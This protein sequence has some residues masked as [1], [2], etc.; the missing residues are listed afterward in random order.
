MSVNK[1]ILL[2]NVGNDPE[3]RYPEKGKPVA[4]CSLATNEGSFNGVE[5][6]EWH[7]LVFFGNN[8]EIVERYVKKGSQLYIEGKLSTREYQ[9][10][11]KI[12]RKITEI[13]VS[14]FEIVG[15]RN[16]DGGAAKEGD[17]S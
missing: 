11:M 9:D 1:V 17:I 12:T 5:K 2:G 3:V 15:K 10:R 4:F 14:Y 6:T 8:A 16:N 13:I 7:R